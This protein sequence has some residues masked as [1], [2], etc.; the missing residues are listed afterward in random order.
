MIIPEKITEIARGLRKNM[1]EPEKILWQ[2]LRA[3]RLWIKFL[4]Q[5][6][7]NIMMEDTSQVRC[8]IVDFYCHEYKLVIEIDGWVHE[9]EEVLELDREKENILQS[10]WFRILR[11]KNEEI[12]LNLDNVLV[13]IKSKWMM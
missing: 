5:H 13:S 8:I 9:I 10:Q 12:L 11:F 2:K 6:S 7:I 3:W 1:T 4:R